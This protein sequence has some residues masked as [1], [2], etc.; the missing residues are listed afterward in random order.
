LGLTSP[1]ARGFGKFA[2]DAQGRIV[3]NAMQAS[4]V[5]IDPVAAVETG[6]KSVVLY[7]DFERAVQRSGGQ[8]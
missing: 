6:G 2:V 4:T 8:K 3:M 7:A 1:V 5:A